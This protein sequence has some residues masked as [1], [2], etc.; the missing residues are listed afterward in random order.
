MHT[1]YQ[2]TSLALAALS[3][4]AN[5]NPIV[6]PSSTVV[7]GP[8]ITATGGHPHSGPG[9]VMSRSNATLMAGASFTMASSGSCKVSVVGMPMC[10][11]G[12]AIFSNSTACTDMKPHEI[13][14]PRKV[15]CSEDVEAWV[16]FRGDTK[17]GNA[18]LSYDQGMLQ[19]GGGAQGTGSKHSTATRT[20][21]VAEPS[22]IIMKSVKPRIVAETNHCKCTTPLA[23]DAQCSTVMCYTMGM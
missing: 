15:K 22:N 19:A 18:T 16:S 5:A 23:S 14:R 8:M 2:L 9:P 11:S 17:S 21:G 6:S 4:I 3:S 13:N 10:S 12:E 20:G 7:N 1:T